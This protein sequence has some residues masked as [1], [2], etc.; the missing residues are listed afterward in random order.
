MGAAE[1]IICNDIKNHFFG[2]NG[3]SG[4]DVWKSNYPKNISQSKNAIEIIHEL[5]T[6]VNFFLN[7]FY[8]PFY[9]FKLMSNRCK[10][11]QIFVYAFFFFHTVST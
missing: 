2:L 10:F 3:F 4:I 9:Q 6:K 5:V 7:G 11:Q 8:L 1:P